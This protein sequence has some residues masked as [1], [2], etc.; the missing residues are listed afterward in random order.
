MGALAAVIFDFDGVIAD[1]RT[2]TILPGAAEFVRHAA[3]AVPLAI[4]S[5]ATTRE[6]ES[7][8]GEHGLVGLFQAIVGADQT[9][10]SK[11]SPDPF[12]EALHRIA[13]K[14]T[15]PVPARTVAIDDS[16][17][18]LVAARTAGLRCVGVGAGDRVADLR[19]HA[20]LVIAGLH[21]LTLDT[22]DNL[23]GATGRDSS[24]AR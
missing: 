8:L 9:A 16:V 10:R 14:G 18:G 6:I 1:C 24:H 2:G 17:W 23:V 20:E 7:L 21:T 22:L 15:P 4:A 5:G 3:T 13:S 19:P 11:P 12:L